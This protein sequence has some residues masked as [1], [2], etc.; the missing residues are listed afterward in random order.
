MRNLDQS[1]WFASPNLTSVTSAPAHGEQ[2]NSFR[3]TVRTAA[4]QESEGE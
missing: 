3:M 4:P 2:A 1:N